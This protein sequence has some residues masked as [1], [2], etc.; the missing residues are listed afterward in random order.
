MTTRPGVR[1]DLLRLPLV[2]GLVRWRYA[3]ALLQVPLLLLAV[4]AVY[5]G[6]TGSVLPGLNVATVSVW[7]HYRGLLVIALAL[8]GNLFCAAC[9]L[10]LLRAPTNW[11]R[12]HLGTRQWPRPL[13]N[14]YLTLGLTLAFLYTYEAAQLWASPGITAALIVGYFLALLLTDAVFPAGTFCRYVCPLG[15]FNMLLSGVSP[16]MIQARDPDVCRTCTGKECVNGAPSRPTGGID[17]QGLQVLPMLQAAGEHARPARVPAPTPAS[18]S[19]RP[20]CETR[21]YVPTIRSNHDCTLCLNCVRACPHDNVALVLR[22]PLHETTRRLPKRDTALALLVLAWG[23]IVNAFAMT[24]PFTLLLDRL[25]AWLGSMNVPLLLVPALLGLIGAGV[26]VSV[27]AARLARVSFRHAGPVLLPASLAVW[28]GHYLYHFLLGAGTLWPAVSAA[29]ARLG[30]PL[31]EGPPASVPVAD[32]AFV[33]Q[34]TLCEIALAA[35]LWSVRARVRTA[36]QVA[37]GEGVRAWPLF[38]LCLLYVGLAVWVFSLP[39]Q[40]RAGL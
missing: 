18:A 16:T 32:Q 31:P 27:L 28:G 14:R 1:P 35:A 2:R 19:R 22:S 26:A 25:S 38:A 20:G 37:G 39:M 6:F 17:V 12:R 30:L 4:L 36:M 10:M 7:V 24:P 13:R 29:L 8:M 5:D 11:L 15:N 21:L 3:R 9:P 40:V 34:L 23:G 33:W